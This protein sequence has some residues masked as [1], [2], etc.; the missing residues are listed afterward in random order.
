MPKIISRDNK[1]IADFQ[2]WQEFQAGSDIAYA[3]IYRDNVSFLYSYGLK[4]IKD[5]ELIK[6][7]IQELFVEIWNSKHKLGRVKSIKSYLFKSIRRKLIA[8]SVKQRKRSMPLDLKPNFLK[9]LVTPSIEFDMIERQ[10]FDQQCQKLKKALEKLTDRQKEIIHLKY[11]T[12]LSY[13][14]IAEIMSLSKKGTYKL[15]GR[16]IC[17]LRK[18]MGAILFLALLLQ[19]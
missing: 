10:C 16:S 8:E 6:D 18:Y 12:Q 4:L 19:F 3:T 17:F 7:C 11:Y 13:E 9:V 5:K 1:G 2:L 15:M 14:E